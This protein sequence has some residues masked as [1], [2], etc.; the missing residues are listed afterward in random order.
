MEDPGE[1]W[2]VEE[3]YTDSGGEECKSK[4]RWIL[5]KGLQLGKTVVIA[6]FVM[7]SAPL[8]LPPLVVVSA[9][10]FAVSVPFGVVFASYACT[11]K[12]MSKLLPIPASSPMLEYD[13]RLIKDG[14]E[15]E[16][17]QSAFAGEFVLEERVKEQMGDTKEEVDQENVY[18]DETFKEKGYEEDVGEYLEGEDEGSL[19]GT[20][21]KIESAEKAVDREPLV[22]ESKNERPLPGVKRVV[23]VMGREKKNA[24]DVTKTDELVLVA[25]GVRSDSRDVEKVTRNE[26]DKVLEG[27]TGLLEKIRDKG[28]VGESAKKNKKKNK[29][30][31]TKFHGV[32]VNKEDKHGQHT[33]EMDENLNK[34]LGKKGDETIR[35]AKTGKMKVTSKHL[36]KE[37]VGIDD[38]N[39]VLASD[40]SVGYQSTLTNGNHAAKKCKITDMEKPV[41][42]EQGCRVDSVVSDEKDVD[43]IGS[44]AERRETASC[45][46]EN[47]V[48]PGVPQSKDDGIMSKEDIL[49][50]SNENSLGE[51]KIWEQ[52]NA[53]R[54]IVGYK[55]A[56]RSSYIEELK[57]LYIFTGVEPPSS[58]D[59]SFDLKEAEDKLHFLMSIVGVK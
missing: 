53:L 48:Q 29:H 15:E 13:T 22:E 26:E 16:E 40:K 21:I 18:K 56:P 47:Q 7:S 24:N 3:Y 8:V 57:A 46:P 35:E 32:A 27:T 1:E 38:K 6:G 10:G 20:N 54:T 52:I 42:V 37:D 2:D 12:L 17:G 36:M 59:K 50:S 30:R 11:E 39:N 51:Q 5:N 41:A 49:V 33:K 14:E 23:V 9:L 19:G 28:K 31:V 25:R 55:A 34:E 4:V 43:S 58:F 44:D 45:N